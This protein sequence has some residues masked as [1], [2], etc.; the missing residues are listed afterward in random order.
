MKAIFE[1]PL[2]LYQ[3]LTHMIYL[4][5]SL[6]PFQFWSHVLLLPYDD[7]AQEHRLNQH[8]SPVGAS[9]SSR[10]LFQT[11]FYNESYLRLLVLYFIQSWLTL[12]IYLIL[13]IS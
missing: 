5:L 12:Y 9:A 10:R 8:Y 2:T 13:E 1:Y 11:S 4:P 7:M 6:V 3:V